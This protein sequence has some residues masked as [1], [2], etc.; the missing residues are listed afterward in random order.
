MWYNYM[1]VAMDVG[2]LQE[3]C[4]ALGRVVEE[5]GDKMGAKSVDEDV[6]ERLVEAVVRAPANPAET[7]G[8]RDAQNEVANPNE[9]RGLFRNVSILF[10]KT[11]LSRVSSPRIFRAYGRLLTWESKWEEALKAYLDGYRIGT[12]GTMEKGEADVEKWREAVSEVEEIVDILRNFGPRTQNSK[13]RLQ[14]RSIVRAFM[15]RTRDFEDEPE[16]GRLVELQSEF[17]KEGEE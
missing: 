7:L 12:A 17:Q 5:T 2:E 10:E 1:I 16:W 11:I 8:D 15:A 9:G 3:T 4:R 13:W 14:G 6:L